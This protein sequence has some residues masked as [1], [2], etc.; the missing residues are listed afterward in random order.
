MTGTKVVHE[1]LVI[2][3]QLSNA[4]SF[5]SKGSLYQATFSVGLHNVGFVNIIKFLLA[6]SR[7]YCCKEMNGLLQALVIKEIIITLKINGDKN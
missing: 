5:S 1:I 7:N 6:V 4:Q 2:S 3:N